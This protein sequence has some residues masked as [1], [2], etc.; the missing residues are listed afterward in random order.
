MKLSAPAAIIVTIAGGLG[1]AASAAEAQR[2]PAP[3][4]QVRTFSL[5]KEE[6]AA[7]LPLQTALAVNNYGAAAAALPAAQAAAQ[8]ADARYF[9]AQYQLRLG[10]GTNNR[11]LQSRAI[12][13]MIASGAVPAADLP[14]LYAN[15]AALL[16]DAGEWRK[17]EAVLAR[18]VELTPNDPAVI[19]QL[20]EL[21]NDVGKVPEAV[22]LIERAIDMRAA[23]GQ[24]VPESLYKR[25]LK[26][27]YDARLAAP[28]LK[29]SR[30][31]VAAYP[32]EQN[33]RDAVLVHR[34][35][36][37]LDPTSLLDLFRLKRAAGALHGERDYL[38]FATALSGAGHVIEAKSVLD[39][40]VAQRMVDPAKA[41][42]KELIAATNRRAA[43]DK[44]AL[45][46]LQSKAMAAPTGELAL[47]A[48]DAHFGA[49]QYAQA[50]ELYRAAVQK[51]AVDPNVANSRLG[52]ALALAG[53]GTE[54]Q[55]ALTAV[56]GPR[57]PLA[58]LWLAWLARRG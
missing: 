11:E 40:G 37:G 48:A 7:L 52:A 25:A 43:A 4:Q 24:P 39:E 36:A 3:V 29:F 1:L 33:W 18:L 46:G 14:Q 32:S 47:A 9:L 38:E 17:A 49:G 28:S 56:S 5:T 34:E 21:K 16:T 2:R 12:D 51:G 41:T 19:A 50:A 35:L 6:R 54:A 10:I 58:S 44:A 26:M 8:S 23:S 53:R 22:P 15:Q 13:A 57:A 20:A 42:F 30:A 55:A 31:L 45:G 27:A